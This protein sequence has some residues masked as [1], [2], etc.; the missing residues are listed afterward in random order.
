MSLF[1]ELFVPIIFS[2]E[3]L[4]INGNRDTSKQ[5]RS[6]LKLLH[7]FHFIVALIITNYALSRTLPAT[8]LLQTENTDILDGLNIVTPLKDLA[9]SVRGSRRP[10]R[11]V[12]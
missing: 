3:E 12:C 6:F 7:D 5:A 4:R 9:H 8:K 11:M 10:Q 1:V 2:L